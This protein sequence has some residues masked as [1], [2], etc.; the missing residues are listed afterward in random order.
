ML[1]PDEALRAPL[2]NLPWHAHPGQVDGVWQRALPA[3]N[4][5]YAPPRD[6]GAC[7]RRCWRLPRSAGAAPGGFGHRQ[8]LSEGV[9][10]EGS[11]G[12][13]PGRAWGRLVRGLGLVVRAGGCHGEQLASLL[14]FLWGLVQGAWAG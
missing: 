3:W 7:V 9:D 8:S 14:G 1:R 4:A 5:S 2:R 12:S 11:G 10:G 6:A 13:T